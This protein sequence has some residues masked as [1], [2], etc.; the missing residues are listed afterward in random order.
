M[1][2]WFTVFMLVLAGVI[3]FQRKKS[4]NKREDTLPSSSN[5]FNSSVPSL[6]FDGALGSCGSSKA[7]R[8]NNRSSFHIRY[9]PVNINEDLMDER[10]DLLTA[11]EEDDFEANGQECGQFYE[12]H[13]SNRKEVA[14]SEEL[15]EENEAQKDSSEQVAGVLL[16]LKT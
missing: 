13:K 9:T 5:Y 1:S 10:R 7:R 11:V 12:D 2:F 3:I 4:R 15:E 16:V 14:D 6:G 8:H